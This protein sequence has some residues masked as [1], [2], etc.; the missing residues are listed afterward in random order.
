LTLL[1]RLDSGQSARRIAYTQVG[2]ASAW[3]LFICLPGLLETRASFD[4]LISCAAG[5][6]H[7]CWISVDYCGRGES[8]TLPIDQTYATSVYLADTEDL[9]ANLLLTHRSEPEKKLHLVGTSMGGILAMHLLQRLDGKVDTLILNDIGMSL[10]WS[11]L[12]G[13]YLQMNQSQK[14]I[15]ELQVD[16][17]VI[18]AVNTS[19]HFDLPYDFDLFSMQFH[20]LLNNYTGKLA[21][22]HNAHSSI[23]PKGIAE[24]SKRR[25]PALNLWT[26]E[27]S[28][29]PA[30][31]D[32][33]SVQKL[34]QLLDLKPK[35][36]DISQ[37]HQKLTQHP[38]KVGQRSWWS[39]FRIFN[40][41]Y[42]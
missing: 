28:S 33:A 15:H 17:R 4:P 5:L 21:L 2:D 38:V 7:C 12:V 22:L 36:V 24:Q 34:A 1:H 23:C 6:D 18:K 32:A 11:A 26:Q 13:L 10:N 30:A 42:C 39:R 3:N 14:K 20:P 40:R 37:D 8:D 27:G 31:W 19:S 35:T 41:S 25:V 29:H 16:T 9:I